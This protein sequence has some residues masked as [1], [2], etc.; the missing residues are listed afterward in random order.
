MLDILL[1]IWHYV[2][3]VVL[4]HSA[5]QYDELRIIGY[6]NIWNAPSIDLPQRLN[7]PQR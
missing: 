7:E 4:D 1:Q 6:K 2:I 5:I 3:L